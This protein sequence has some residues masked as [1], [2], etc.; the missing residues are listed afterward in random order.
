M[1]LGSAGAHTSDPVLLALGVIGQ[2]GAIRR[3]G[4]SV[5][6][7]VRATPPSKKNRRRPSINIPKS[8][9]R[10]RIPMPR[11]GIIISSLRP[12]ASRKSKKVNNSISS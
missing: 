9:V 12:K 5:A 4:I 8:R 1:L 11:S 7:I 6:R 3:I 2:S 10:V